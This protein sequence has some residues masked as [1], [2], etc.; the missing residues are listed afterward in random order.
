MSPPPGSRG[1]RRGTGPA[2]VRVTHALH[3]PEAEM[4]ADML[5][6]AGIPALIRRT[7]VD[8]PEMLAGGPR[9]ILVPESALAEARAVLGLDSPPTAD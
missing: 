2:W 5:R 4:L 8:V 7:T 6:Q 1:S 9:A 3:Q